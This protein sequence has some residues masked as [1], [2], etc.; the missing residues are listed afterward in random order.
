MTDCK[1]TVLGSISLPSRGS[2][3]LSLTVLS[4]IGCQVVFSLGRW[5]SQ[6]HS[7]FHVPR[8]TRATS[9]EP[10]RFRLR[11]FYPLRYTVPGVSPI[12]KVYHSPG[13]SAACPKPAALNP[14]SAAPA[15]SY[16]TSGLGFSPFARHY[17]GN[18]FCF[19]F[20]RVLRYFSSPGLA[21]AA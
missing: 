7:R 2:F 11:D 20:L 19:L 9:R 17:L 4:T 21:P 3:H 6:I 16:H 15:G 13:Q 1:L 12:Q 8:A 5:S 14:T 10:S 18:R